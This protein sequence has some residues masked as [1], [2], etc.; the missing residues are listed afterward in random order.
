MDNPAYLPESKPGISSYGF[1][2][3]IENDA[4]GIAIPVCISMAWDGP[5]LTLPPP[6]YLAMFL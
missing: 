2:D 1:P 3:S 4:F 6:H 5:R